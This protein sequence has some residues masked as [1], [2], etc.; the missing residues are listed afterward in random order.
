MSPEQCQELAVDNRSDLFSVGVLLYQLLT[1]KK[2][3]AAKTMALVLQKTI[4]EDPV[5]PSI[6]NNTVSLEWDKIVLKA[7]AKQ[8]KKRFQSAAEFKSRLLEVTVEKTAQSARPANL[9]HQKSVL[10]GLI[11]AGL[12]TIGGYYY[13][14]HSAKALHPVSLQPTTKINQIKQ[15]SPLDLINLQLSELI[16]SYECNTLTINADSNGKL[17][18]NGSVLTEDLEPI[19]KQLATLLA[20][21]PYENEITALNRPFCEVVN[22]ITP[23]YQSNIRNDTIIKIAPYQHTT[24][25]KEGE[26]IQFEINTADYPVYLYADYFASDGAILHLYPIS[27]KELEPITKQAQFII[28]AGSLKFEVTPPFGTDLITL[29][30]SPIPLFNSIQNDSR[31]VNDYLNNLS[32]ELVNI[33]PGLVNA[34]YIFIST[35]PQK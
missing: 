8:P 21:T 16:N 3:Y 12:S 33:K 20:Q 27:T 10:L 5:N 31:T 9:L 14:Y 4:K 22:F 24:Q 28:G 13:Y 2:P 26:I 19:H 32:K 18:I 15:F 1:G 7:L 6:V 11:L 35:G 23:F 17:L 34:D 25:Y 30:A 29:I